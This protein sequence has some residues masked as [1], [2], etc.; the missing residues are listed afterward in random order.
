MLWDQDEVVED[1][2]SIEK[3]KSENIKG[4]LFSCNL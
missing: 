4:L 3:K 1:N 2:D